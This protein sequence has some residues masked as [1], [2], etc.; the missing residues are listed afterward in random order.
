MTNTLEKKINYTFKDP[1]LLTQ[2][3][4]HASVL[5]K[6]EVNAFERLEFLGDRVLGLV[7][8]Q[9]LYKRYETEKEGE[10]AKKL[11]FLVCRE[12]LTKISV[13]LSLKKYIK[14]KEKELN[15]QSSVL[16]DGVESLLGAIYLDSSFETVQKIVL[17]LWSPF[18]DQ[19]KE[20]PLDPK[21]ALQEYIQRKTSGKIMPV[22]TLLEVSGPAHAPEF[23]VRVYVEGLGEAFSVSTT[24]RQA[25]QLA[26]QL[27]LDKIG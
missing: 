12:T 2:A 18:L 19:S 15:A 17:H 5:K 20:L 25:E 22:Y 1:K 13:T 24:K 3:L 11:A 16:S 6:G 7:I 9:E 26:A 8:A 10:L 21:S 27:L 23:H 4:T 14:L